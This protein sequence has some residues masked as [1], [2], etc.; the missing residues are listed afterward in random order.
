[1]G[2]E[3]LDLK[4]V[5][6]QLADAWEAERKD[7]ERLR[8][9]AGQV[10][11]GVRKLGRQQASAVAFVAADGGDNRIRLN[12][13]P[14]GTPAIVELVRVVDS[15]GRE[16]ALD[17]VAGAVDD[18]F[19]GQPRTDPVIRLCHDLGAS[20]MSDLS[21]YLGNARLSR[22]QKMGIYRDIVEWAVLYHLLAERE[23]GSDTLLVREGALRTR[24]FHPEVFHQLDSNIRAACEQHR[25]KSGVNMFFVSV[26]KNTVLLE[27][28][29]FALSLEGAFDRDYPCYVHV[30]KEI[31]QQFYE[32]RWLDTLETADGQ[33]YQSMA[34]MFLVKFGDHP[35]DPIWPVDVF[36]QQSDQSEKILGYLAEDA[37]PG[38]P[39][40]DFPMCIQK[41][42]D[43]A[44]IG[45]IELSFLNDLLFD[46]ITANMSKG[47]REKAL[48]ARHLRE[49]PGDL[50]YRH[51]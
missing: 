27:R 4:I 47:E 43:H 51:E 10:R 12:A 39:I 32:R 26:A 31:A 19:F 38:F 15:N 23:W 50:R 40:P 42:H 41:A 24:S 48:R 36:V 44:K 16:C 33:E 30:R 37:R 13:A 11:D 1:M 5:K 7:L 17:A 18:D 46:H 6:R 14:G 45:G 21:P 28:L 22:P 34:E 35:L 8:E 2:L 20:R 9:I 49:D 3:N 29:R 25:Q